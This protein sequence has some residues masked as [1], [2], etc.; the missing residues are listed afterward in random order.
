LEVTLTKRILIAVFLVALAGS[1]Q[2]LPKARAVTAQQLL[3]W[4]AGGMSSEH[5]TSE[6]VN[7]GLA[8]Q[9]DGPYI[10][11]LKGAGA[12][13]ALFA[14][15]ENSRAAADKS[16]SPGANAPGFQHLAAGARAL[17]EKDEPKAVME[18]KAALDLEPQNADLMFALANALGKGDEWDAAARLEHQAV[19]FSPEFW[20]ARLSLSYAC[21][22]LGDAACAESESRRVLQVRPNDAEAHKNLG[23]AF[24]EQGNF[25]AAERQ[26]RESIRLKPD[27]PNAYYDLGI[28]LGNKKDFEGAIAAY[29]QSIRLDPNDW[30]EFYNLG[31]ILDKKGDH[32]A[33]IEAYKKAKQLAPEKLEIRQNL[34]AEY[35][36]KNQYQE[37]VTEFR[38]LLALD[39]DWNMARPCLGKSLLQLHK[40]DE[41]MQVLREGLKLDPNDPELLT[42]LGSA[43]VDQ[44]LYAEAEE[45]LKKAA[46]FDPDSPYPHIN[47]ARIAC[48]QKDK[49]DQCLLEWESA[50]RVAPDDTNVILRA[51]SAYWLHQRYK[52]AEEL[53][54]FGID[55]LRKNPDKAALGRA[56]G[57]LAQIYSNQRKYDQAK[58]LFVDAIQ[59]LGKADHPESNGL[60]AVMTNYQAMLAA[61]KLPSA[62][63]AEPGSSGGV[64]TAP[65]PAGPDPLLAQWMAE[66]GAAQK[67][68]FARQFDQAEQTYQKALDDAGKLPQAEHYVIQT[69]QQFSQFYAMQRKFPEAEKLLQR[70]VEIQQPKGK[71]PIH[72]DTYALQDLANIYLM[73]GKFKPA[74][75]VAKQIV[76]IEERK[77]SG[78]DISLA[79]ALDFL[80]SVYYNQKEYDRAEPLYQRALALAVQEQG[81]D[82]MVVA[83]E[84]EHVGAL[85]VAEGQ[86]AKAEPYFRRNLEIGEKRFGKFAP[87]ISGALYQLAHLMRKMGRSDEA[88]EFQQRRDAIQKAQTKPSQ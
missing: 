11:V 37:A 65:V 14:L 50:L 85:Y 17:H 56:E 29:R 86:Y 3:A 36:N 67:A 52:R 63:S 22:R 27:Y 9:P 7:R 46:Q 76:E 8:F 51:A 88:A 70:A 19:G 28:V 71:G 15:L 38:E 40:Y 12:P 58:P 4:V 39:P 1:S 45:V 35:C 30:S 47:L 31:I 26:F 2:E 24:E 59:L 57:D 49:T 32:V 5:L 6:V 53:Y 23:L 87:G 61:E 16:T 13:D 10:A 74:E 75:K 44:Q 62:G 41:G 68:A 42:Y 55:I 78:A 81:S 79:M 66:L 34:G 18:L 33:S 43:L 73:Q 21:Y 84:L 77:P 69:L 82:A 60:Q 80:G 54:R 64:S 20:E 48:G 25:D 83:V 72:R